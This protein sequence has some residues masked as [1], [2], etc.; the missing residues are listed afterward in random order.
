MKFI[1]LKNVRLKEQKKLMEAIRVSGKCPFCKK[2]F[3]RWHKEPLLRN[4]RC[5]ILTTNQWPYKEA[6]MHLLLIAKSHIERLSELSETA[7][8]ELIKIIQWAEKKFN[9][10]GG[11]IAMRF[12]DITLNGATVAHLHAHFIVPH[13]PKSSGFQPVRFRISGRH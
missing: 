3:A 6:K 12:G 9:I 4:G 7:G 11:G 8:A 13:D 10:A 2:Q 1:N 5:W